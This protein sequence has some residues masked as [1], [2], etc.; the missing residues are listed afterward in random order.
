MVSYRGLSL[1]VLMASMSVLPLH[2]YREGGERPYW[3]RQGVY[4]DLNDDRQMDEFYNEQNELDQYQDSSGYDAI[5]Y[6]EGGP[7]DYD[8]SV[9]PGQDQADAL[10]DSYDSGN[11]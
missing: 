9:D 10:F 3:P 1:I 6:D 8:N 5:P 7:S 11:Q 2:A 4:H